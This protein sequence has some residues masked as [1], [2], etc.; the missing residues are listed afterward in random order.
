MRTSKAD[1][2]ALL[3]DVGTGLRAAAATLVPFYLAAKYEVPDLAIT[4]LGGWLGTLADPG[5][6]RTVRAKWLLAFAASGALAYVCAGFC[7][8]SLLGSI[9]FLSLVACFGS[10]FRSVGASAS[11]FGT[12]LVITA[13]IAVERRGASH[14]A[15]LY[16]GAGV[17]WAVMLSTIV[18]PMGRHLP[19]RRRLAKLYM[20]LGAVS[21]AAASA[22]RDGVPAGDARWIAIVKE[23]RVVR[24]AMEHAR[25]VAVASRGR[26][27]GETPMGSNLRL[28]LGIAEGA[29]PLLIALTEH[30]EHL[31]TNERSPRFARAFRRF[32]IACERVRRALLATGGARAK[33]RREAPEPPRSEGRADLAQRLVTASRIALDLARS[34]DAPANDPRLREPLSPATRTFRDDLRTF[35]DALSIRSTF[36]RHSVRVACAVAAAV[37]IGRAVSSEHATWVTVTTVAVLQPYPGASWKR[38]AE[39]IVGTALGCLLAVVISLVVR[40]PLLVAASMLPLSVAA[41]ATKPRSYRLFTFFLTPVFVLLAQ[42]GHDDLRTV[43]MRFVDAVVGG[44]IALVAALVIFP[45]WEKR[46]LPELLASAV[47][48]LEGYARAVLGPHTGVDEAARHVA[49]DAARRTAG[50]AFGEAE[51]SLERF[52]AEPGRKPEHAADAM[53]LVTHARRLAGA[54]TA[55]EA[56]PRADGLRESET[57]A[58]VQAVTEAA[59]AFARDG[60]ATRA[61]PAPPLDSRDHVAPHLDRVVHHAAILAG[62]VAIREGVPELAGHV[63]SMDESSPSDTPLRRRNHDGD[64]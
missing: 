64:R 52:I 8:R 7:G 4:A 62:L 43:L 35:V 20:D 40:S 3:P 10:L 14:L 44:G 36:F 16:F 47:R 24:E 54:L 53:Q 34:L 55:T 33:V 57:L 23:R 21:E 38:A 25:G 32:A 1:I 46:R 6:T 17:L 30:V 22:L 61:V 15:P 12:M 49:A 59:E 13:V 9:L 45:S 19:V 60:K 42:K 31:P 28:M 26:R 2:E 51:T 41:V 5:G 27:G 11:T 58:Y 50:I 48:A 29:F 56:S 37:V 39:R 63:R 18:W